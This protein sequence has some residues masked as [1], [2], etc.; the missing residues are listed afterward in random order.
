LGDFGLN[1][2]LSKV[3]SYEKL[4]GEGVTFVGADLERLLDEILPQRFGGNP[5]TYQ[6]VEEEV[7]GRPKI[8]IVVSPSVGPL[9]D[10]D[11]ISAVIEWLTAR[12][13][14][15]RL[16][17]AIW[18]QMKSLQV[19]RREPYQTARAKVLPLHLLSEDSEPSTR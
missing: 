6:L 12:P 9:S 15:G 13:A 16:M 10:E 17:S 8:S 4:T 11:V 18:E 14:G 19:V 7:D 3:R 1:V 5:G 2:H